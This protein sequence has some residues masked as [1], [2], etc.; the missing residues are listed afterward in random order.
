MKNKGWLVIV[1]FLAIAAI[2][3]L[4]APVI[5]CAAADGSEA[6]YNILDFLTLSEMPSTMSICLEDLG[7]EY[8]T[9]FLKAL[10][11]S[12][13]VSI[14]IGMLGAVASLCRRSRWWQQLLSVVGLV[15]TLVPAAVI[16]AM[17]F[18]SRDY[19]LFRFHPGLYPF[20]ATLSAVVCVVVSIVCASKA[21]KQRKT[22]KS[23]EHLI[24]RGTDL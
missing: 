11:V 5:V 9:V 13:I 8:G 3:S 7:L 4:I 2:L 10:A 19:L 22:D 15:G 16:L 20:I 1:L 23:V 14:E 21:S 18:A 24:F 6:D 17:M 12:A